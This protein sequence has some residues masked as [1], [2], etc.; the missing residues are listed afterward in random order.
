MVVNLRALSAH[1]PYLCM[2]F[3]DFA[4]VQNDAQVFWG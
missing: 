3:N 1:F 2:D 4:T